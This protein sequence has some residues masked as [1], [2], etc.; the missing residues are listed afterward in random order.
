MRSS[1]DAWLFAIW[2]LSV[3]AL[4]RLLGRALFGTVHSSGAIDLGPLSLSSGLSLESNTPSKLCG[5]P[6]ENFHPLKL[7]IHPLKLIIVSREGFLWWVGFMLLVRLV[8][9]VLWGLVIISW[10]RGRWLM[11]IVSKIIVAAVDIL[12]RFWI[13]PSIVL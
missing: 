6:S 2:S 1:L 3:R 8:G 11:V 4:F 12:S 10:R 13:L 9:L 7:I 5:S